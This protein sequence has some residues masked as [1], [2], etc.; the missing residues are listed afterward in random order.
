MS[1]KQKNDLSPSESDFK[2]GIM[3]EA[4]DDLLSFDSLSSSL[5]EI[6]NL[7]GVVGYILRNQTTAI[8][9]IEEQD[10]VVEYAVLSSQV[11]EASVQMAK[12]FSLG[13][14]ES[15][16]VEGKTLKLLC[17]CLGE[18]RISVFMDKDATHAWIIKRILI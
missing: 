8:L 3:V 11:H 6:R 7:T 1:K 15:I 9:D 13:E 12:E 14:A 16:L 2:Q 18:N 17:M 4:S 5:A 10:K